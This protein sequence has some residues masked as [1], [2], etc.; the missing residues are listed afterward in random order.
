MGICRKA[1]GVCRLKHGFIVG[2][3]ISDGHVYVFVYRKVDFRR[4]CVLGCAMYTETQMTDSTETLI[5][6][7]VSIAKWYRGRHRKHRHR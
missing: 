2:K 7:S 5:G 1:R 6:I 4:N 3:H